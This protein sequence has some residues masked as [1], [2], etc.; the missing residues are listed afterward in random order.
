M[1]TAVRYTLWDLGDLCEG[2]TAILSMTFGSELPQQD[3]MLDFFRPLH[4]III[5][6]PEGGFVINDQV[7]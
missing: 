2:G 4:N 5:K 1:L 3:L 6:C 7:L